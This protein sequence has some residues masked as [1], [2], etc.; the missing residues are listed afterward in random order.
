M[1]SVIED[2][3]LKNR[4]WVAGVP[5]ARDP[6]PVVIIPKRFESKQRLSNG[7]MQ[8]DRLFVLVG[9]PNIFNRI[10]MNVAWKDV[11]EQNT[12]E[13]LTSLANMGQAF[14]VAL[15][16]QEADFFDGDGVSTRFLIQRRVVGDAFFAANP[17]I[18]NWPDFA[19][20]ATRYS[21]PFGL[22]GST[23][24]DFT[25]VTYKTTTSIEVSAPAAGEIWV[26][27]G[28]HLYGNL[29][30][31]TVRVGT[32]PAAG[33]DTFRIIYIPLMRMLIDSDSGR[34]FQEKLAMSR[35]FKFV[36]Q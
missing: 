14:D 36:E 1:S 32:A 9:M 11:R 27:D 10:E 34:S 29:L 35:A 24:T 22:V 13:H 4:V 16:K 5:L 17:L 28:G 18:E 30:I 26:E 12:L 31:S 3:I 20:K 8:T 25:T 2:S 23:G 19:L 21:A 33:N 15:Y 6:V 7:A